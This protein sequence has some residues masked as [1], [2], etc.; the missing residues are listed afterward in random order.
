MM[1][2]QVTSYYEPGMVSF[3]VPE[4][5]NSHVLSYLGFASGGMRLREQPSK[6]QDG[7][8]DAPFCMPGTVFVRLEPSQL[9]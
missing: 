4:V 5:A 3:D 9:A 6:S 7:E 1:S 8:P 2:S